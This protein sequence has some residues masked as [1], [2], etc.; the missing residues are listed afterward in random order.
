MG[1]FNQRHA[2]FVQAVATDFICSS[3]IRWRLGVHAR[4]AGVMSCNGDFFAFKFMVFLLK[5]DAPAV[6]GVEA[7]SQHFFGKHLGRARV[8]RRS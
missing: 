7:A 2:G 3:D 5:S 6:S 8:R 1:D 4:R